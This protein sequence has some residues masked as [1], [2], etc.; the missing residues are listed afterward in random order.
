MARLQK[1]Y[2]AGAALSGVALIIL[3][4]LVFSPSLSGEFLN[5]DDNLIVEHHG[6][7]GADGLNLRWWFTSVVGGDYKPLVWASYALDYAFWGLN[8]TGYHLGNILLHAANAFLLYVLLLKAVGPRR[9]DCALFVACV[10]ALHPLRVEPVCWITGR[11]D[12]LCAF[13]YLL[14]VLCYL[15]YAGVSLRERLFYSDPAQRIVGEASSLDSGKVCQSGLEGPPTMRTEYRT[16]AFPMRNRKINYYIFSVFCAFLAALSKASAA[17]LPLVLILIDIFPRK[18]FQKN[19]GK[20]LLEKVP[21]LLAAGLAA[22]GALAGQVTGGLL[23][24][25]SDV[26]V[27]ERISLAGRSWLFYLVKTVFPVG[28]Q[29]LYPR[30]SPALLSGTARIL[31]SAGGIALTGLF[32]YLRRKKKP[33]ALFCWLLYLVLLLPI[34]GLFPTGKTVLA[35]RFS[36]LP[37]MAVSLALYIGLIRL[38][39]GTGTTRRWFFWGI[40]FIL[41]LLTIRQEMI[42]RNSVSLWRYSLSRFPASPTALDSLGN[43]LYRRGEFSQSAALHARAIRYKKDDPNIYYNLA[44]SLTVGGEYEEALPFYRE[45]IRLQPD[46]VRAWNN[47]GNALFLLGRLKEA[48]ACYREVIRLVPDHA[49]AHCNLGIVLYEKGEYRAA[50]QQLEQALE[51]NPKFNL[52]RDYYLRAKLNCNSDKTEVRQKGVME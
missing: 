40:V 13:F 49:G 27:G 33:G 47:L 42:W 36:Y 7:R 35:D 2:E 28:L 24:S 19:P 26:G 37:A 34:S 39:R 25:V 18:G 3:T 17:T 23:L 30:I 20:V 41:G 10:F 43:A 16:P 48:G 15:H 11:K 14:S 46:H 6:W 52:A 51:M 5:W 8:P 44:L 45:A 9:V 21:Y 4:V 29:P 31:P 50:V 32:L 22:M 12:V 38:P 1:K